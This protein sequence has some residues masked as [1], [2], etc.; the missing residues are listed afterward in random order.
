MSYN[1]FCRLEPHEF[2]AV[3]NQFGRFCN[4]SQR[5]DW[6]RMRILAAVTIQ[7]YVKINP[8]NL[9]PLPWDKEKDDKE[10]EPEKPKTIEERKAVFERLKKKFAND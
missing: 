3:C 2:I 8:E 6:E 1:D 10:K 9:L 5:E 7:P 4:N